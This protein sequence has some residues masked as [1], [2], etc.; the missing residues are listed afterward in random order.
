MNW[1]ALLAALLLAA[2]SAFA[3][4]YLSFAWKRRQAR[5]EGA[6][7]IEELLPGYDCSLCG[8]LDCRSYAAAIDGANTDP[9]LCSPGGD[10]T[11]A[12]IRELLKSRRGDKRGK[13]QYAIVRCGGGRAAKKNFDY[14]GHRSCLSSS[15]LFG[16]PNACSEG[17]IGYGS[18]AAVCPVGA[19]VVEDGLARVIPELCSGCGMCIPACPKGLISLI[20]RHVHWFVAC[21]SHKKAEIKKNICSA[22][23]TACGECSRLSSRFEFSVL[24]ELARENPSVENG[25][26]QEIA[27]TCPS[28]AIVRI[29]TQKK[30]TPPF[31]KPER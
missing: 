10:E 14:S 8:Y 5:A 16:G 12:S 17:C 27:S 1:F 31:Q 2:F 20:P 25:N 22:A 23:C 29:G 13:A 21:A 9:G 19:I 30:H 11:E 28:A 7:A 24:D 15:H 4:S 18:C 6:V 26:W 3:S